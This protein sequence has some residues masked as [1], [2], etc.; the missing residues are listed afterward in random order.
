M[1][2][3]NLLEKQILRRPYYIPTQSKTGCSPRICVSISPTCDS[4][5]FQGQRLT[6]KQQKLREDDASFNSQI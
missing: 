5:D 6:E 4:K 1:F 2:P 3:E